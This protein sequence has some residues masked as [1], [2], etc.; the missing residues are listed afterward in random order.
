MPICLTGFVIVTPTG[1]LGATIGFI[2]TTNGLT[3]P[4]RQVVGPTGGLIP[5]TTVNGSFATLCGTLG[6]ESGTLFLNVS[7]V[8]PFG[9]TGTSGI[10]LGNLGVGNLGLGNLGLGAGLTGIGF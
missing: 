7:Q 9:G 10:G 4:F 3:I 1:L 2:Y 6:F 5:V 8:L